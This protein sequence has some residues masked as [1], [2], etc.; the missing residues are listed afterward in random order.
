[1]TA[2]RT[3]L[4]IIV[5]ILMFAGAWHLTVA[6]DTRNVVEPIIPPVYTVL[7]AQLQQSGTD[8]PS[9]AEAFFDTTRIQAA[10]NACASGSA[11]ELL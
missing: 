11:V 9:S 6:Q 4:C 3:R 5:L 10:M 7:P 8:L 2:L 1:M